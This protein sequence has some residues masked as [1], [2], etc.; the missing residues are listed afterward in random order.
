LRKFNEEAGNRH[1]PVCAKKA[2]DNALK[3]KKPTTST[4]STS[5]ARGKT[6]SSSNITAALMGT[7]SQRGIK[8][9]YY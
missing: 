9:G 6:Q 4:A 3:N 5:G 8:K 1:I 2:K 7:G